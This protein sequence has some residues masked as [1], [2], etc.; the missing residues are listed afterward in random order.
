M[1]VSQR[2]TSLIIM[3][4]PA[5]TSLIFTH[6]SGVMNIQMAQS[7]AFGLTTTGNTKSGANGGTVPVGT[8]MDCGEK[9]VIDLM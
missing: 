7:V 9:W 5:T 3:T 8:T 4:K 1:D 2:Y 6:P